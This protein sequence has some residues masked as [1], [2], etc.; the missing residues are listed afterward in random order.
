MASDWCRF[1]S[2]CESKHVRAL[3]ASITAIRLF[4]E[5]ESKY[6][7]FSTI[8]RYSITIGT[9]HFL[10]NCPDPTAHRQIRLTL[11]QLRLTK[12]GDARQATPLTRQHLEQL[13]SILMGDP[14]IRNLRDLS[15]Y[16][17][18][19]EC[20]LKRSELKKMKL[21]ELTNKD[22]FITLSFSDRTYRLSEHASHALCQW[23]RFLLGSKG[24]LYRRIDK[25]D[26]I[27][28]E[29]LDDSSIYRILRRASDLLGLPEQYRF[30]GQSA[31]VGAAQE[32][33]EQGYK[34]KDIQD[35]G[36]WLS[37][38]MP[39][40]YLHKNSIAEEEKTKFKRIKPWE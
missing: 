40:Q 25:H 14:C 8:R 35:F 34:L 18:M 33:E 16:Y 27:G 37:P 20:A 1:V 23:T 10:H 36:R 17:I 7:K 21:S 6:R 3:P 30:T 9:I 26:N 39:A 24:F 29:Q 31:R 15:I 13:H 12:H 22:N 19:F 5:A 11:Q 28:S 2:F 4:L 38:A 32:L